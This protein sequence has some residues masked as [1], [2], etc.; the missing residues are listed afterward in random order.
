MFPVIK[1]HPVCSTGP[2]TIK[3][4]IGWKMLRLC[5]SLAAIN[6]R[7][8]CCSLLISP[9]QYHLMSPCVLDPAGTK[10]TFLVATC[11]VLCF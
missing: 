2:S 8:F 10:L 9:A 5:P 7:N 11:V 1:Y 4:G 6:S 3:S